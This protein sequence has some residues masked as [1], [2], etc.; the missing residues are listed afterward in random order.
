M[1]TSAGI[2]KQNKI[3]SKEYSQLIIDFIAML[4]DS[5]PHNIIS[6]VLYGSV[7]KGTAKKHSDIDI[8]LV[9]KELPHSRHKRTEII[10]PLVKAIR[11]KASYNNL[12]E[13]GY[14]PEF[15]PVLYT[16]EEIQDTKPIFLDMVDDGVILLDDGSFENKLRQLKNDLERLGSY[17]VI[18][19]DGSYYWV[20]K[21][22]I[23]MGE[24]VSL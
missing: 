20:L 3:T 16:L 19:D 18:L 4:K 8:C 5:F 13:K 21:P 17:K 24:I 10:F 23:K 1:V 15:S 2:L 12:Y 11:E 7:A 6:A 14:L 22:H 9:F